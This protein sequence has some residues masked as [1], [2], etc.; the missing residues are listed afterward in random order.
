MPPSALPGSLNSTHTIFSPD[1]SESAPNTS[2]II[3]DYNVFRSSIA[4]AWEDSANVGGGR[5]VIR[6]RKGVADRVWEETVYALVGER[7]GGDDE[8]VGDKV[9]GV[10]L[11]VRKDED[12]LSL[13]VAPSSRTDRDLIRYVASFIYIEKC[14][15]DPILPNSDSLRIALTPLL[16]ATALSTLQLDYK[17][18]P[19][20]G[21]G[22]AN[23]ATP[24]RL[25]DRSGAP[26]SPSPR[27]RAR[28]IPT[29]DSGEA[30]ER[31]GFGER[32][33]GEPT[34]PG[35]IGGERRERSSRGFGGYIS[36]TTSEQGFERSRTREGSP[37][38]VG[39]IGSGAFGGRPRLGQRS[40]S[41]R[42]DLRTPVLGE[43][44]RA[45][46]PAATGSWG[47]QL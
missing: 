19:A 47:R 22:V 44:D 38:V 1:S 30:R 3:C 36:R 4:P 13:W 41:L 26:D 16:G 43:E 35:A 40:E 31:R 10:V 23:G 32:T 18:H 7:I 9:N 21:G 34:T 24:S 33:N 6:L 14:S 39:V 12:I 46:S 5:W 8:R 25:V 17:P 11:S 45:A 42:G 20:V 15:I 28:H 29:G 37:G 27:L 2:N